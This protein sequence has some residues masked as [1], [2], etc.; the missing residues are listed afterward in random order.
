MQDVTMTN[1]LKSLAEALQAFAPPTK[2]QT[3]S[4]EER[5]IITGFEEILRF[6]EQHHRLPVDDEGADIF[7]RLYAVRL[8]QLRKHQAAD[9]LLK[10]L[11][12]AGI[13][14]PDK[15]WSTPEAPAAST[16]LPT[17]DELAAALATFDGGELTKLQHVRSAE[18]KQAE[19]RA[20]DEIARREPCLDFE[21]F[22]PLF[23]QIRADLQNKTRKTIPYDD[24]AKI[25]QGDLFILRGQMAY[26]AHK[27]EEFVTNNEQ[28]HIDARLRVIYDN[29][30]ESN[31]LMRSLQR[32]LSQDETARR[33]TKIDLGPL[34]GDELSEGDT[35]S[36]TIYVLRSN[37][38]HHFVAKNRALIH[39]IGVTSQAKVASRIANAADQATYLLA[40]V[41]VV[42]E[43]QLAGLHPNSFEKI[44]HRVFAPAQLDITIP[45]RF[46]KPV[47][48]R[49]WF[50]VPL[51]AIQEVI[52]RIQDGSITDYHYNPA[53]ARLEKNH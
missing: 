51:I 21:E 35:V 42:A 9:A 2:K 14:D 26:V 22:A 18:E 34:F 16:E 17:T 13:L 1:D 40:D 7:E 20:A 50:L 47:Q 45:D 11:D 46:G 41:E 31:L 4:N 29:K 53:S 48:P 12:T 25:R 44:L 5:R 6:V 3:F 15:A 49:E 38:Q 33:I 43:Y 24:F 8:A 37:S 52:E 30:T 23:E 32:A 39:K 36:G 19:K 10:P 27:G 28:G